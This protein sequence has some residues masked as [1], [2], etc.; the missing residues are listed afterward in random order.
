MCLDEVAGIWL[1]HL[2]LWKSQEHTEEL[3]NSYLATPLVS[4]YRDLDGALT[5][6]S[7]VSREHFSEY[8]LSDIITEAL[9]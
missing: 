8:K 3:F 1:F 9:S 5:Q 2:R 6:Q 4:K 7:N